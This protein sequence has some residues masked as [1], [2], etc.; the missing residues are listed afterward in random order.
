MAGLMC[1]CSTIMSV[2]LNATSCERSSPTYQN[3]DE[4]KNENENVDE[5]KQQNNMRDGEDIS[6]TY[7]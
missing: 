6:A 4:D 5:D 2:I 7:Q 1:G 3:K